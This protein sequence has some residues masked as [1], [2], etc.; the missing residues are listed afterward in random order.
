MCVPE[1]GERKRD[2]MDEAH[3]SVYSM[4]PGVPRCTGL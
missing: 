4:H 1:Y 2:I 3:S